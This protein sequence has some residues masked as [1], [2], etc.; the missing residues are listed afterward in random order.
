MTHTYLTCL[1]SPMCKFVSVVL[2]LLPLF[3]PYMSLKSWVN[4]QSSN[5]SVPCRLQADSDI[6]ETCSSGPSY[7]VTIVPQP[8]DCKVTFSVYNSISFQYALVSLWRWYSFSCSSILGQLSVYHTDLITIWCIVE[9]KC[10]RR[11][12]GP[13]GDR[14]STAR[15]SKSTNLDPWGSQN[16]NHQPKNIHGLDLGL[17]AQM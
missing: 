11:I 10:R 2:F 15:P 5:H 6:P 12:V 4:Y 1:T 9:L 16:L 14:N 17:L 8:V 13:K 3:K 7:F